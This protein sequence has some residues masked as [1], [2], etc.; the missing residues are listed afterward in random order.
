[1]TILPMRISLDLIAHELFQHQDPYP[2]LVSVVAEATVV[3]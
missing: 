3:M 2:T 1:M